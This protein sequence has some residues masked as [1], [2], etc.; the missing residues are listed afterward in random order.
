MAAE[1]RVWILSAYKSQNNQPSVSRSMLRSPNNQFHFRVLHIIPFRYSRHS[2]PSR[3]SI[4]ALGAEGYKRG[5][6]YGDLNAFIRK[7]ERGVRASELGVRHGGR[8]L[9][10]DW[11]RGMGERREKDG[12]TFFYQRLA[13]KKSD[14]SQRIA[15]PSAEIVCLAASKSPRLGLSIWGLAP[16]PC[17]VTSLFLP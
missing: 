3:N 8:W 13:L 9:S 15:R 4:I 6:T 10:L 14:G 17:P 12:K 2:Q 11:S 1:R 16:S 5:N 7:D